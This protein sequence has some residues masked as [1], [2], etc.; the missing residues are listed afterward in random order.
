MSRGWDPTD[1]GDLRRGDDRR[2]GPHGPSSRP[3]LPG[4]VLVRVV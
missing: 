1:P 4:Y 2:G 3:T